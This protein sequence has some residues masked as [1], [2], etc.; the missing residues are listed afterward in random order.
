METFYP[1]SVMTEQ[2]IIALNSEVS[3]LRLDIRK[4]FFALRVVKQW[5]F[6]PRE[7]G[8]ALSPEV[9]QVKLHWS[10]NNSIY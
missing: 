7:V 9:F 5:N 8:N 4:K 3:R 1:G 6:L 10:L 2:L